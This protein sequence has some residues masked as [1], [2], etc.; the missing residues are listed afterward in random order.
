MTYC[1][2]F[3]PFPF[4]ATVHIIQ[5]RKLSSCLY[6]FVDARACDV[7]DDVTTT[8]SRCGTV[9]VCVCVCAR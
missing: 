7:R 9:C 2:N 1:G 6:L 5:E 4:L 8:I 3:Y